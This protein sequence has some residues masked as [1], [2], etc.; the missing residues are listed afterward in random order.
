M[1][2]GVTNDA[3]FSENRS[4]EILKC[5]AENGLNCIDTAR[6]YGLS[7][8]IIGR[9]RKDSADRDIKVVT[10]LSALSQAGAADAIV[11][12]CGKQRSEID[13]QSWC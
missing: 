12:A 10:K 3:A 2:Y 8:Q 11:P 4:L 13:R 9:F 6:D 7:E 1:A 5:A